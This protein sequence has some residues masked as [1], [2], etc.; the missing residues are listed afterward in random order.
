MDCVFLCMSDHFCLDVKKL[1]FILLNAR[2]FY[3]SINICEASAIT[4]KQFDPF[5]SC[6]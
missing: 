4:W 5:R 2:Y 3:I 1:N 6:F